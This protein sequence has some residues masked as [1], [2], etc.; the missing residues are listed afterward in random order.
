VRW[1]ICGTVPLPSLDLTFGGNVRYPCPE[2]GGFDFSRLSLTDQDGAELFLPVNRGTTALVGAC[3]LLSRILGAEPPHILTAGDDG[4]GGGSSLVYRH[5]AEH[6]ADYAGWGITFHYF[7]PDVDWHNRLLI[8][9]EDVTPRPLL[10]ADA[11]FMYAAKMSG[12]A[13]SYDLFFPDAGEL[14]FLADENAPHPFYTR[15]F[16]MTEDSNAAELAERAHAHGNAARTMLVK[17]GTDYVVQQGKVVERVD[18]PLVPSLEAIGGTG[19]TVAGMASALL[20]T[21]LPMPEAC[22]KAA[23]AN[24][25]MGELS[26]ATPAFGIADLLPHLAAAW[27]KTA[28]A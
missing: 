4:R 9:L 16:F 2:N 19:D 25:L 6:A 26:F 3:A 28:D 7:L 20:A 14:A 24:R 10:C 8:A 15:G 22:R 18:A 13:A 12:Y 5:L 1:L 17:G 27:E 21:G 23:L 11:G